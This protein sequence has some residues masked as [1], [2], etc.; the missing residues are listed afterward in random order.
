MLMLQHDLTVRLMETEV[1][2]PDCVAWHSVGFHL[3]YFGPSW[4][5]VYHLWT[6]PSS[7]NAD[8]G[9]IYRNTG[10]A[11]TALGDLHQSTLVRMEYQ[12]NMP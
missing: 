4:P 7:I 3:H 8:N 11:L 10:L 2:G 1:T 6:L 5:S 9:T 12:V